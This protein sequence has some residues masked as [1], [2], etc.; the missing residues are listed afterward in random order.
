MQI[1][2]HSYSH[3]RDLYV[4]L[5]RSLGFLHN[6]YIHIINSIEINTV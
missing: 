4:E 3:I 1:L 5:I 6:F 2:F